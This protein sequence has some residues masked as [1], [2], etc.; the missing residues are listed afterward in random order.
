M[1]K[2]E[3]ITLALI[4]LMFV[5]AIVLLS[6]MPDKVPMHWNAKGEVDGYGSRETIFMMPIIALGVYAMF[7]AI[8]KLAVKKQNVSDFY[9]KHG[10]G[11]KF[12]MV[13]FFGV[14]HAVILLTAMGT[15]VP[16]G[17]VMPF[18]IGGLMA[19]IGYI[20]PDVKRNYFIGI[21]TPWALSDD[22][23]WKKTHEFGGKA[24]MLSGFV[25]AAWGLLGGS[26]LVPV[27]VL[28]F[29]VLSS[30]VYSYKVYKEKHK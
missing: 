25:F 17:I 10:F 11:F 24:F 18:L 6:G 28:L 21:R 22:A 4:A 9:K 29:L 12:S 7:L 8:P 19:Y 30:V 5:S 26:I 13:L 2:K 20:L 14:M 3:Y 1:D 16:M 27:G 15:E 23:V